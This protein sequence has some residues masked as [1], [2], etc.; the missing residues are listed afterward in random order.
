M[1]STEA[2][3]IPDKAATFVETGFAKSRILVLYLDSE[4]SLLYFCR[5]VL[6]FFQQAEAV[7]LSRHENIS[8]ANVLDK[9]DK[10]LRDN[11]L[12]VNLQNLNNL[13]C[14]NTTGEH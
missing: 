4:I 5:P 10:I 14:E 6:V 11:A 9:L 3:W 13:R 1:V 8:D 7:L 12:H 2:R